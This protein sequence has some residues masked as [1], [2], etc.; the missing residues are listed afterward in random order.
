MLSKF[1]SPLKIK[2]SFVIKVIFGNDKES[3]KY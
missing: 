2:Y 1:V 3:G